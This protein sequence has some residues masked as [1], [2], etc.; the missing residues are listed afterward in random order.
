MWVIVD[1]GAQNTI[2]NSKLRRILLKSQRIKS[3]E[4]ITMIDVLGRPVQAD[5]SYIKR[6]RVGGIKVE[7]AAVAFADVHPFKLFGLGNKPA[8][9]AGDG[10]LALLQAGDH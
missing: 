10:E 4:P 3:P 6:L 9:A 5:Y 1:T 8:L 7:N 2:G